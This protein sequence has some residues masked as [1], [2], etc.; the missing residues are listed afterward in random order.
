M[1][2]GWTKRP[3][4]VCHAVGILV[5]AVGVVV[6]RSPVGPAEV[7]LA[8]WKPQI[9]P[10]APAWAIQRAA[11]GVVRFE[12]RDGDCNDRRRTPECET[13]RE[14]AELV[15]PFRP[16][17]GSTQW[18]G[19][20]LFIPK[21]NPVLRGH[22]TIGQWWSPSLVFA[23]QEVHGKLGFAVYTRAASPPVKRCVITPAQSARGRWLRIVVFA[24]Y[25]P[26]RNRKVEFFLN[27]TR[28]CSWTGPTVAKVRRLPIWK[29]GL[30]RPRLRL[31]KRPVPTQI[32]MVR[33]IRRGGSR[34]L[35]E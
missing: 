31:V 4:R 24:S 1:Q 22:I 8:G 5:F 33:H 27:G 25:D 17:S 19:Y 10:H 7:P 34:A 21:D 26:D 11:S 14:R 3:W 23:V 35:V 18:Y 9:A 30:Y 28:A 32:V 13:G 12:V 2:V 6:C 15:D 29:L 20:S 16:R